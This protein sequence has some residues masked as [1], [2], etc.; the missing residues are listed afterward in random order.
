MKKELN[1]G[2]EFSIAEIG[3]IWI[4]IYI[5]ISFN[6]CI[7]SS[8]PFFFNFIQNSNGR[9]IIFFYTFFDVRFVRVQYGCFFSSMIYRWVYTRQVF[10]D[11]SSTYAQSFSNTGYA[12]AIIPQFFNHM[13][14]LRSVQ[15][16]TNLNRY[17][18]GW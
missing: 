18:K 13:P 11:G 4:A 17:V 3:E 15:S 16:I 14:H 9:K 12:H 2:G 1:S 6:D 8:I 7:F 5:F 10:P